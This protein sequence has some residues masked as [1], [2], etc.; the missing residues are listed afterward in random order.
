M[1]QLDVPLRESC[2]GFQL[3]E[4]EDLDLF[5]LSESIKTRKWASMW[6]RL[7][8]RLLGSCCLH[9]SD[10]SQF[11]Q[12]CLSYS[13]MRGFAMQQRSFDASLGFPG[14]GPWPCLIFPFCR[15]PWRC[16]G[17][18]GGAWFAASRRF[19]FIAHS[20]FVPFLA[21]LLLVWVG[22]FPAA[23]VLLRYGCGF[24]FGLR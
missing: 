22:C 6:V 16:S 18:P 24:P 9:F 13:E 10:R 21:G 7:V 8:V 2:L 17:S 4:W 11:K 3:E 19:P 15:M 12:S 14:E 23:S 1:V 5:L 20:L